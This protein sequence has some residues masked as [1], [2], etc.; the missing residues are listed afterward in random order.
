M[1]KPI[2]YCK[3]KKTPKNKTQNF[4]ALKD[5]IRKK[6]DSLLAKRRYLQIIYL[7]IYPYYIKN[8]YN[9]IKNDNRFFKYAKDKNRHFSKKYI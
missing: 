3:V 2:Q 5:I 4:R 7:N 9:S 8:S 1:A 6:I